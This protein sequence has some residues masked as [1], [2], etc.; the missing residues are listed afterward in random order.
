MGRLVAA[1]WVG[2]V[3]LGITVPL[4]ISIV[5]L[6]AGEASLPLLVFAI[7]CHTVGAFCA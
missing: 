3:I 1:F 7:V 4:I 6:F 5:S 2:I